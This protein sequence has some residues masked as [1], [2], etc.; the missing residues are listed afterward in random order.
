MTE[1]VPEGGK[2]FVSR[3][4]ESMDDILKRVEDEGK[5]SEGTVTDS[6]NYILE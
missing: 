1:A 2:M 4:S 6:G 5:F 3:I